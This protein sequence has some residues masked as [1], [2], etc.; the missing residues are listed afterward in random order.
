VLTAR[1]E[2]NICMLLQWASCLKGLSHHGPQ[3]EKIVAVVVV[4]T[5]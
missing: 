5:K 2:P 1:N 3:I 4:C